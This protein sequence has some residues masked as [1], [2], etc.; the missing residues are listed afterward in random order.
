MS[1]QHINYSMPNAI[2]DKYQSAYLPH[3]STETA[4]T[5]IINAI[6]IYLD[7]NKAPCSLLLLYLSSAFDTPD[8][9]FLSIGLNEMCIIG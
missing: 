1:T 7:D 8:Y 2:F 6:L 9:N 5:L 4:H 3:S